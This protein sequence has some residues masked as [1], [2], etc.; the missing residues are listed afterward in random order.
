ME[1]SIFDGFFW[2]VGVEQE[3]S[4]LSPL[5]I[6]VRTVVVYIIAYIL[7][8]LAKRR[9]MGDFSAIDIIL[10]FVVGSVMARAITGSISILNMLIVIGVLLGVHWAFASV[11]YFSGGFEDAVEDDSRK[12]VED[13]KA[14]EEALE[15]S[16]VT[17]A[18]LRQACRENGNVEDIDEIKAAYL[19]RDG[20]I[21]IIKKTN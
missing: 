6:A 8:R 7:V 3:Y 5:Q 16:K 17:L 10:G 14:I 18:E 1:S 11:S 12:L 13:G 9:F 15:K 20:S 2:L 4:N 19:E 21:S